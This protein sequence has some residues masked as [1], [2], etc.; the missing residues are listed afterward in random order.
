MLSVRLPVNIR[1][2]SQVLGESKVKCRFLT[3]HANPHSVQGST[4]FAFV[5]FFI[6]LHFRKLSEKSCDLSFPY[7]PGFFF[8]LNSLIEL[9]LIFGTR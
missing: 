5:I 3:A 6:T 7:F 8:L 1:L 9:L 4:V 2:G